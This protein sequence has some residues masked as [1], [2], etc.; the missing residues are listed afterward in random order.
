MTG[1]GNLSSF[2]GDNHRP[3][4]QRRSQSELCSPLETTCF[5]VVVVVVSV[6]FWSFGS[7]FLLVLLLMGCKRNLTTKE[8]IM[9]THTIRFSV[10]VIV[11][12]IHVP[13]TLQQGELVSATHN[14]VVD[15]R[16]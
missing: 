7:R 5:V 11:Y 14:T 8:R 3:A 13:C 2:G 16:S 4:H 10:R 9:T 1:E 6:L 12:L 15:C